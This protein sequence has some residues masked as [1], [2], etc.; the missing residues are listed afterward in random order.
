MPIPEN[1]IERKE[2]RSL[3]SIHYQKPDGQVEGR[4]HVGHI[5]YEN[6]LLV[7]D[8]V[9][10]FRQ[11][12]W[13]L[14]EREAGGWTFQYH[15]FNPVLPQYA[16]DWI[17]FRDL[18]EDK[19]QTTK[20]KPICNHVLGVKVDS[21]VGLT[22]INAVVYTDAFG[23]GIDLILY[24]TRSQLKKCVRIR[25]KVNQEYRFK[26]EWKVPENAIVKRKDTDYEYELDLTR[27]KVFDTL[28]DTLIETPNGDSYFKPFMVWDD[29]TS[30]R[31]DVEF[32]V[33]DGKLFLEKIIPAGFMETSTGDVL[34]DTTASYY[35]G[36][37]DGNVYYTWTTGIDQAKWDT[38]HDATTGSAASL[39]ATDLRV[40]VYW[41]A[42]ASS[43]FLYRAFMP[44][45]TSALPDSAIISAAS[46]FAYTLAINDTLNDANSTIVIVGET[47]QASTGT[48][49]T[50][51]Y[52]TC[53]SVD[54]PTK[55]SAD[56][57]ISSLAAGYNEIPLNATGL[58]WINK[59]GFTKIGLREGHDSGDVF[60]SP[61][62]PKYEEWQAYTHQQTGTDKD[63]YL[64]VTYT[65]TS[66]KSINGLAVASIKSV[67]GLAVASI[68]S[69]NGL[70]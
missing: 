33:A 62:L 59:T 6:K 22:D 31:I 1:S 70:S 46:F 4:F 58:S 2:L 51:D 21:I 68:K 42:N 37:G 60:V 65:T 43:S 47:T 57:D 9:G 64:S 41:R 26:F 39:G 36:E 3:N 11:L 28:K 56:I 27:S 61:T 16:D 13:T 48:L 45:D 12:D 29:V 10:G 15:S 35:S 63:P 55:G 30:Q 52:D 50:A 7:G 18:F 8:G 54:S 25:N 53:G 17:E 69:I 40:G 24:F 14:V 23:D 49:A 20:L 32:S 44:T 67:N 38:A 66:I 19:D 34:T 5:M